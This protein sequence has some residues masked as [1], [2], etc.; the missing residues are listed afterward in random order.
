MNPVES[1]QDRLSK[2]G[3][4]L[5]E[6]TFILVDRS[7]VWLV[8]CTRGG[9]HV[10][11]TAPTQAGVWEEACRLAESHGMLQAGS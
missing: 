9:H 5:G 10:K 6:C 1:C 7:L 8:T 2:G 3:W 4:S 11:A